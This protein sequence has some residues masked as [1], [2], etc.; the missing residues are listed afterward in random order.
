MRRHSVSRPLRSLLAPLV[1]CL[2]PSAP[3]ANA[4]DRLRLGHQLACEP[5]WPVFCGNIHVACAGQTTLPAFAF[6]LQARGNQARLTAT[7]DDDDGIAQQYV[8]ARV[9]DD[10]Q[11]QSVLLLPE[12]ARGYLKLQAD[13]RYS[14]RHY[15]GHRG[16]MS[17]G[18][19]H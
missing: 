5:A 16:I 4:V 18:Q 3:A 1:L 17:I 10:A 14:L 11:N 2:A 7:G 8:R 19:C 9:V 13:G 15:Q 6:T 12:P